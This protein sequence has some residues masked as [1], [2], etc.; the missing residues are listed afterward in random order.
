MSILGHL[1]SSASLTL[2]QQLAAE[3]ASKE[4]SGGQFAVLANIYRSF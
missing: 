4:T 3:A 2:D 1:Q